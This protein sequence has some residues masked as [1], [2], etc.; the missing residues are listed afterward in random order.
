MYA[1]IFLIPFPQTR[2]PNDWFQ[3]KYSMTDYKW[4][5]KAAKRVQQLITERQII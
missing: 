1:S 5:T 3:Q 2:V 4:L